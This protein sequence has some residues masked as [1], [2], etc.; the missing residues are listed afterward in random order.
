V[1]ATPSCGSGC[2]AR[3]RGLKRRQK[4]VQHRLR[5]TATIINE[6]DDPITGIHSL[7]CLKPDSHVGA[8]QR[9]DAMTAFR[10]TS[11]SRTWI[12]VNGLPIR[13]G[14]DTNYHGDIPDRGWAENEI[15][16]HINW[17]VNVKGGPDNRTLNDIGWFRGDSPGRIVDEVADPPLIAIGDK[18]HADRWLATI[19]S[20]SRVL[21][22]NPQNPCFHSDP[23]IPDC[24]P[25]DSV[26]VYGMVFFHQGSLDGLL[27]R[28][29]SWRASTN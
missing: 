29:E 26:A 21:F 3:W 18:D 24:P 19:W 27:E 13:L 5:L 10:D 2:S 12:W 8:P 7:V 22:S 20:P 23:S 17:G 6:T 15:R 4:P 28:V 14:E 1:K 9:A 25:H 11:F 16:S